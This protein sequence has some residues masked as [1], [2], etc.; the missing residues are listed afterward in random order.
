MWRFVAPSVQFSLWHGAQ[1][2]I[3]LLSA[4]LLFTGEVV[5]HGGDDHA[6]PAAA[7]LSGPAAQRYSVVSGPLEAVLVASHGASSLTL[8]LAEHSTNAP[9]EHAQIDVSGLTLAA[10]VQAVAAGHY[11]LPLT[12]PLSETNQ[13]L[14][15]TVS[16]ETATGPL[17]ELIDFALP[18][19]PQAAA[20]HDH[21]HGHADIDWRWW[22]SMLAAALLGA[23]LLRLFSRRQTQISPQAGA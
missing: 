22:L 14:A 20:Q 11:L 15:L 13:L 8:Y 10:P 18:A 4:A 1:W 12:E 19:P 23:G 7:A 17:L 21:P 3:V 2:L 6:E 9:L 16:V 5:A